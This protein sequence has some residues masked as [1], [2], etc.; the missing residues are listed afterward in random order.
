MVAAQ[1][2]PYLTPR[3]RIRSGGLGDPLLA[4]GR[5][6]TIFQRG[7]VELWHGDV[8]GFYDSWKPPTVIVS[9][10][11]YGIGGFPGDPHTADSLP[12]A[13]EAHIE[14][15][16]RRA[17]PSTTL[18]FWNTELGWA[19]VHPILQKHGWEYR[20][21]HI[22]NKGNGHVAGNAN[23]KTLRK[24]P[25]ITEVCVQYVR[26]V[27]LAAVGAAEPLPLRAWLRHEWE[28]TGLPFSKTNEACGVQNAATRKYF[29]KD[30]LWYFPPADAF[31]QLVAYANRYG[32]RRGRP[33]FSTDGAQSVSPDEWEKLRAKFSCSFGVH[34]VWSEPPVRNGERI[35]NGSKAVHLNQKPLSLMR[36]ILQASSDAR[37]VVW[38]PFGGTCTA[39]MAALLLKRRCYAAE[40]IDEY[41][42]LACRRLEDVNGA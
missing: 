35:K 13:Y 26:V 6:L 2:L 42:D 10:G 25:V 39:A 1:S 24:F 14:A 37:D 28:R 3:R 34:N 23:T 33:Y 30:H 38:E 40:R 8:L 5:D 16:S 41:F 4:A 22:W 27:K 12:S 31:G 17:L 29:T 20:N 7:S 11:P 18:W 9:D 32:N 21:C 19:T 15:W 36:L